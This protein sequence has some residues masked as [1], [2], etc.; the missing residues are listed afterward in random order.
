MAPDIGLVHL[1][2]QQQGLADGADEAVRARLLGLVLDH[3]VDLGQVLGALDRAFDDAIPGAEI[4]GLEGIVVAVLAEPKI[5]HLAV[6]LPAPIPSISGLRG[7]RRGESCGSLAAND[8]QPH[9]PEA[10][11]SG[12]TQVTSRPASPI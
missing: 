9:L 5:D 6:Q 7:W 2:D 1:L 11:M 4:V 12:V 10:Q 8:P 3:E